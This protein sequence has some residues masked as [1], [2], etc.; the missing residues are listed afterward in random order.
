[1]AR[2][3]GFVYQ[4]F[5]SKHLK[6]I[7]YNRY[8]QLTQWFRGNAPALGARCPGFNSRI[9]QGFLYLMFCFVV[10]V[11]LPFCPKPHYLSQKFAISFAMLIYLVYLTYC[12]ICDRLKGH[13][14]TVLESST[15]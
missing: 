3:F 6:N 12:N 8:F 1:V 9:R 13:K 11:F 10:V 15:Y 4:R 2:K 5:A 7:V 14:D